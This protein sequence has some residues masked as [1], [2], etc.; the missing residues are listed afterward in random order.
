MVD[1]V[2]LRARDGD[3]GLLGGGRRRCGSL[4]PPP[5]GRR[6]R[7]WWQRPGAGPARQGKAGAGVAL[8]PRVARDV[9]APL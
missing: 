9:A 5:R 1:E 6:A 4:W 7:G 8:S 3:D 2:E